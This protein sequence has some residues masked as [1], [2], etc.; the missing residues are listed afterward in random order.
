MINLVGFMFLQGR[1]PAPPFPAQGEDPTPDDLGCI[2]ALPLRLR[3][4]PEADDGQGGVFQGG[5]G[6]KGQVIDFI[7]FLSRSI[8]AFPGEKGIRIPILFSNI[9]EM[10]GFTV[11]V[12]AD[13]TKVWFEKIEAAPVFPGNLKPELL[14][15][16]TDRLR[17]GY[18]SISAF[19][20]YVPPFEGNRVPRG[21]QS[22]LANLVFG[23]SPEVQINE[24]IQIRFEDIP[25]RADLRPVPMNEI[26]LGEISYRPA[27]DPKGIEIMIVPERTLFIRGDANRDSTLNITD[28]IRILHFLFGGRTVDCLDSTD[29]DDSGQI[30]LSDVIS[31]ADFLFGR[32]SPP[33]SP[34]P[35]PGRDPSSD[36]LGDCR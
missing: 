21:R 34:F 32:G 4:E 36:S 17:D 29:V 19:M 20:D 22:K 24:K 13:P 15:Q 12:S 14:V 9:L 31:L 28:M 26:C 2:S 16:Y 10:D 7:E 35:N 6:E 33:A 27:L 1:Y 18:L 3:A 30:D 23:I 5:E 25:P 11:S 8:K